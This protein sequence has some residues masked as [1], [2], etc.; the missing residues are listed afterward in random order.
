MRTELAA[1]AVTILAFLAALAINHW[2]FASLE[3]VP[4]INWVYLPAGV[5]LLATLLYAEAGAIGLLIVSWLVSFYIFFPN[6]HTRAF[7]GGIIAAVAPY[8]VYL[9]ARH[10]YGVGRSLAQLSAEQ[11]F[12]LSLAYSVASPL[13]H[14]LWFASQGEDSVLPGFSVM[15]VGD[16]TGT[17]LVLFM[18]KGVQRLLRGRRA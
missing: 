5:R 15:F 3:F 16:L 14:H 7:M 2:L 13:L 8:L 1:V 6:D 9:G 4:G 10:C 17:L 11:L 18:V 12:A